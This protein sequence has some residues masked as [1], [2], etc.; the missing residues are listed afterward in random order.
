MANH[1]DLR[2]TVTTTKGSLFSRFKRLLVEID[3]YRYKSRS[4]N[5]PYGVESLP[6]RDTHAR[7]SNQ[8][9][10]FGPLQNPSGH[11]LTTTP[12]HAS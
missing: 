12:L 5:A 4:F 9:F 8:I 1:G 6:A 2:V 7:C 10:R 3:K 11:P